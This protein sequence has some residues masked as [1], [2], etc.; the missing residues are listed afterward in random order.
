MLMVL[1]S[2]FV[3]MLFNNIVLII[4]VVWNDYGISVENIVLFILIKIVIEFLMYINYVINFFLYCVFG[5]K[6]WIQLVDMCLGFK[7]SSCYDSD[8]IF[9]NV[10]GSVKSM[11]NYGIEMKEVRL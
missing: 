11:W 8:N 2:F 9:L 1:M 4:M 6:F 3:I 10:N 7:M 5:R